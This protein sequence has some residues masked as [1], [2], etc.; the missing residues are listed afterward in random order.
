MVDREKPCHIILAMYV[1][2]NSAR[3]LNYYPCYTY[4]TSHVRV[5]CKLW[6]TDHEI[7]IS[8]WVYQQALTNSK[9]N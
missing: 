3:S 1:L 7:I 2:S 5:K 9:Q 6:L 4:Y 8:I